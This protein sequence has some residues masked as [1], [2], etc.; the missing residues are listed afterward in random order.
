MLYISINALSLVILSSFFFFFFEKVE[1]ILAQEVLLDAFDLL[2]SEGLILLCSLYY[3]LLT[4]PV[5]LIP[6]LTIDPGR[7]LARDACV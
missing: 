4:T 5:S 7:G 1:N 3:D 6:F 2:W